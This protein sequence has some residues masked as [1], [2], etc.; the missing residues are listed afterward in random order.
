MNILVTGDKGFI[1]SILIQ[2]LKQYSRDIVIT[3][4]DLKDGFDILDEKMFDKVLSKDKY[5][6]IIHLA[7][8]TSVEE[9][10]QKADEYFRTNAEGTRIVVALAKRHGVKKIIYA[11]TA[12]SLDPDSSPYASS[13]L[14]GE[15][16]IQKFEN[17]VILRLFNVVGRRS[18]PSYSGVI[19]IFREGIQKGKIII[20]GDGEQTRDF[21]HIEDVCEA[22]IRACNADVSGSFEIGSGKGI[23]INDLAHMM[24]GS[25]AVSIQHAPQ[26]KEVRN[27]CADI[28]A[29]KQALGFTP[30]RSISEFFS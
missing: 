6:I 1:G 15:R 12:A 24:I 11:A 5:D 22:F 20:Y 14:Q 7:A 17:Y 21:I 3:G 23:T 28:T 2:K 19:D 16:E 30:T 18:N 29:A 4:Y 10:Q 9:S 26:R 8:K 27:S 25:K 13:K